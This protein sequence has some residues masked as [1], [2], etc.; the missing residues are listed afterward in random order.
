MK[1]SDMD[2]RFRGGDGFFRVSL[3]VN[4]DLLRRI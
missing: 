1:F 4:K 2:P 3:T